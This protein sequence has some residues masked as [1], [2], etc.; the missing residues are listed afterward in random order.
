M[1]ASWFGQILV[2]TMYVGVGTLMVELREYFQT[3]QA[4]VAISG[5]LL[6]GLL[7]FSCVIT[8]GLTHL[9]GARPVCVSGALLATAS[10]VMTSYAT[11]IYIQPNG[12]YQI[13]EVSAC[14]CVG[15]PEHHNNEGS[16]GEGLSPRASACIAGGLLLRLLLVLLQKLSW[17]DTLMAARHIKLYLIE[18]FLLGVPNWCGA[19]RYWFQEGRH[20]KTGRV[21][22]GI[23]PCNDLRVVFLILLLLPSSLSS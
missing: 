18:L 4:T 10:L 17:F 9:F 3:S 16:C 14:P 23:Q 1:V 19:T 7:N 11:S 5:A 20:H 15:H 6:V 2:G 8:G 12:R 22:H 21:L 13:W